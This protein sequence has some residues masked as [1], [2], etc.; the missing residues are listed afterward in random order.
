MATIKHPARPTFLIM[1]SSVRSVRHRCAAAEPNMAGLPNP[2]Q[3]EKSLRRWQRRA[4]Q[5]GRN[6]RRRGPPRFAARST[7]DTRTGA[8]GGRR[9]GVLAE[10]A[11]NVIL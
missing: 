9:L 8:L 6:S 11:G 4:I 5:A 7:G 3:A 1:F 10:P 2:A